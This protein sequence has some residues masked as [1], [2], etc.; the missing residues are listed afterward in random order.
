MKRCPSIFRTAPCQAT[1][2]AAVFILLVS[3]LPWVSAQGSD[4]EA[5]SILARV[6][7]N[8]SFKTIYYE[9]SMEIRSGSRIKVKTMKAWASGKEKA[10]IE[11]TNPEDRGVRF[12]KLDKSLWMYFPKEKDT[13]KIS[14]ALL[15]QGLMGSDLSY[16]DAMESDSLLSDYSAR[17]L[18]QEDLE[19]RKTVV[20][21]LEAK[22]D[23]ASYAKRKLWIDPER[24]V[25][26]KSELYA[27]SGLLLKTSRTLEVRLVGSRHFPATVVLSDALRKDSRTL[28]SMS[29]IILDKPIEP[30]RF[31][32]QSL[33]R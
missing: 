4:P 18:G 33:T 27:R 29:S 25:V 2:L 10:F 9:G 5:L 19:G 3:G 14:G 31:S 20:L 17:K 23:T 30:S 11:F 24:W 16:E 22:D 21:E 1:F 7:A 12:L 8:Q 15:R 28:V 26:L 6:D 32:L 13:V